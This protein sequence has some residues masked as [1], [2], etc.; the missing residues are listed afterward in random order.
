M[1]EYEFNGLVS[2]EDIGAGA[3]KI[4]HPAQSPSCGQEV[5]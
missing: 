4:K 3:A 5:V 2:L 1:N